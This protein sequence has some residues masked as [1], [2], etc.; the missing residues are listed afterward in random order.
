MRP[1]DH[2]P[3][4]ER[5]SVILQVVAVALAAL[6]VLV[7]MDRRPAL[8]DH[9][10]PEPPPPAVAT[11]AAHPSGSVEEGWLRDLAGHD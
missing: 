8:S 9:P 3:S 5:P 10:A 11:G 4:A 7:L 6:T 2:S 1:D